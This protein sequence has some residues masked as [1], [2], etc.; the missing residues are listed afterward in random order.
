MWSLGVEGYGLWLE[1]YVVWVVCL[2][3]ERANAAPTVERL[4]NTHISTRL[5]QNV[6]LETGR[7]SSLHLPTKRR[8]SFTLIKST[9]IKSTS[10]ESTSI[11]PTSC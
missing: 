7:K 5:L 9:S 2:T 11:K 1:G 8:L 3:L 4:I 10:T 6:L